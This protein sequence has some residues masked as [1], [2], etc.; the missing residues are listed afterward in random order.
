MGKKMRITT[1]CILV[2]KEFRKATEEREY[3]GKTYPAKPK[4]WHLHFLIGSYKNVE[5][6]TF[7]GEPTLVSAQVTKE[8]FDK[9][10]NRSF[11]SVETV[12]INNMM[13]SVLTKIIKVN[14]M[15]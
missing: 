13:T 5:D 1:D 8:S 4:S 14:G 12:D 11:R 2:A 7:Y 9:V 15:N 3:N 6:K 10:Q